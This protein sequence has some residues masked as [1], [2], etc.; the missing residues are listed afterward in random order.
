MIPRR[1]RL[2]N[3]LSYRDCTVDFSGLNLAVLCGANGNGK[4]A[5]L[6]AMTWATWGKAR[7]RVEDERISIGADDLL[8]LLSAD[9]I[10]QR[11]NVRIIRGGQSKEIKV[12]VAERT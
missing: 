10:G 4:S 2:H 1:I 12:A 5:L 8:A 11:V 3:F 9:R 7:G 6:D